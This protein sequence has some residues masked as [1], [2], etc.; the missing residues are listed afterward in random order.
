MK[1]GDI[2]PIS[3]KAHKPP[4]RP[5]SYMDTDTYEK[6]V[7]LPAGTVLVHVSEGKKLTAFA[8]IRTCFFYSSVSLGL[9]GYVYVL[10]VLFDISGIEVTPREVRVDL[11]DVADR[12]EIRYA[13]TFTNCRYWLRDPNRPSRL[14]LPAE[15][16]FAP[17][18]RELAE[19]IK[20]REKE[21][22]KYYL[23]QGYIV[24]RESVRN[25]F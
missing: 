9:T 23:K 19:Q 16:R 13:G 11:G 20:Q 2:V 7:T 24:K 12:V 15:P 14:Y 6:K 21:T 17:E 8:P 3:E 4:C 1:K 22:I 5:Y 10:R 25:A 18:F